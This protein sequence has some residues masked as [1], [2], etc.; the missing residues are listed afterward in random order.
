MYLNYCFVYRLDRLDRSV[1]ET[2]LINLKNYIN[3]I[4]NN[5]YVI[6]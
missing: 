4:L 2:I 3:Y 1:K 6:H 5:Y